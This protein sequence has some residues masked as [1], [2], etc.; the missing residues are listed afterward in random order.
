MGRVR[1]ATLVIASPS[2][3]RI[4][5]RQDPDFSRPLLEIDPD[6]REHMLGR[7]AFLYG[8]DPALARLLTIKERKQADA[9]GI[10]LTRRR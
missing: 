7:L 1:L 2:M 5:Y 9:Q 10:T 4:P 3:T 6:V 8:R